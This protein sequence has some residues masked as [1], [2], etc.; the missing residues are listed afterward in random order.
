MVRLAGME[1]F[2]VG[3]PLLWGMDI[4]APDIATVAKGKEDMV[5]TI[6]TMM[7]VK[8]TVAKMAETTMNAQEKAA[9]DSGGNRP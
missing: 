8:M 4:K 2:I 3:A 9:A 1:P 6:V 7:M 5:M